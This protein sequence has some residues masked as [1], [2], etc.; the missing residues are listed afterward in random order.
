MIDV[1]LMAG[2]ARGPAVELPDHHAGRS[3]SAGLGGGGQPV[4]DLCGPGEIH[5][6]D[7]L[8]QAHPAVSG[9]SDRSTVH[10]RPCQP[11]GR[12][13][14]AAQDQPPFAPDS[15]FGALARPPTAARPRR[16]AGSWPQAGAMSSMWRQTAPEQAALVR[17]RL[18]AFLEP[19]LKRWTA[20]RR[21]CVPLP[22]GVSSAPCARGL[23]G[24]RAS[25][26]WPRRI[27]GACG[28]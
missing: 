21:P 7:C 19:L 24:S 1:G 4:R 9:D 27:C 15:G 13:P 22:G 18:L 11:T 25:T 5:W 14:G 2:P 16:W 17:D 6:S 12:F 26:G 8:V 28:R 20:P 10:H 23:A 3:R